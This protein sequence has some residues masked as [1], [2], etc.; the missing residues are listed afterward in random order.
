MLGRIYSVALSAITAEA[1]VN[2]FGQLAFLN[3]IVFFVSAGL[4]V[5]AVIG[6]VV[7]AWL[8]PSGMNFWL[9]TVAIVALVLFATWPLHFDLTQATPAGFQPLSLIHI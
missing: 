5:T 2:G 7:S 9:R 3:P 6:V 4:L 1:I 8:V